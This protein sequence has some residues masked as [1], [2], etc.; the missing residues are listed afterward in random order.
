MVR[1]PHGLYD[2]AEGQALGEGL[3]ACGAEDVELGPG[4]V[5]GGVGGGAGFAARGGDGGSFAVEHHGGARLGHGEEVH[6]LHEDAED[7]L[8]PEV[9]S[10]GEVLLDGAAADAADYAAKTG[11]GCR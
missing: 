4:V 3:A 11:P 1:A 5:V 6:R 8:D 10:P 2:L 9:P 7:E